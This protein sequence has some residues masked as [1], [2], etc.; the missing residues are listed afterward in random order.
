MTKYNP[1]TSNEV[2]DMSQGKTTQ[3]LKTGNMHV[4]K[5]QSGKHYRI[6]KNEDGKEILLDDVIAKKKGEDLELVYA[7]GTVVTIE[8]FYIECADGSCSVTLPTDDGMGYEMTGE[9]A[10]VSDADVV[11][12]HGDRET[13]AD[14]TQNMNDDY[15]INYSL[16]ENQPMEGEDVAGAGAE[17]DDQMGALGIGAIALGGLAI[18]SGGGD[19]DS[20]PVVDPTPDGNDPD[21]NNPD[22]NNPE[23]QTSLDSVMISDDDIVNKED[24]LSEVEFSG[25]ASNADGET[26]SLVIGDQ[27]VADATVTDGTFSGTVDLSDL[28]DGNYG[29]GAVLGEDAEVGVITKDTDSPEIKSFTVAG[30]N[31]LN[32]EELAADAVAFSGTATGLEGETVTVTL[33]EGEE[34]V[35]VDAVVGEDGTFA[36]EIAITPELRE[37]LQNGEDIPVKYSAEDAAD[38]PTEETDPVMVSADTLAPSVDEAAFTIAG[39]NVV[40]AE[41]LESGA[42]PFSGMT[43]DLEPGQVVSVTLGEG[44]DAVTAEAVV[45]EDGSFSGE[46]PINDAIRELLE[47]GEEV[48]VSYSTEDKAGNPV[49]GTLPVTISADLVAPVVE[50]ITFAEGGVNAENQ[51]AVPLTVKTDSVG[52]MLTLTVTVSNGEYSGSKSVQFESGEDPTQFNLDISGLGDGENLVLTAVVTDAAGNQSEASVVTFDKDTEAPEFKHDV[53][54]EPVQVL[55]T[56]DDAIIYDA[57]AT[58]NDGAV[59][60]GVTY[61]IIGGD[62]EGVFSID[63]QT[64][65]VSFADGAPDVD[66][67]EQFDITIQAT[68]STGNATNHAATIKLKDDPREITLGE[69]DGVKLNLVDPITVNGK[70]YYYLDVSGDGV[71]GAGDAVTHNLL[72]DLLN[73]GIDTHGTLP[74]IG[75]DNS[76]SIEIDGYKLTLPTTYELKKLYKALDGDAPEDWANGD[77]WS[78]DKSLFGMRP[79]YHAT[80]DL[81]DWDVQSKNDGSQNFVVFEVT[82]KPAPEFEV[83][84]NLFDKVQDLPLIGDLP[85]MGLI[86]KSFEMTDSFIDSTI[87]I[88]DKV[89]PEF[90]TDPINSISPIEI[91]PGKHEEAIDIDV[92]GDIGGT[93]SVDIDVSS[94]DEGNDHQASGLLSSFSHAVSN[95]WDAVPLVGDLPLP[96]E[97]LVDGAAHTIDNLVGGLLGKGVSVDVD[98]DGPIGVLPIFDGP[99]P[100]HEASGLLS[101]IVHAADDVWD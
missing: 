12:T 21:G 50:E 29:Y 80:V 92:S 72:D 100:D 49:S 60:E 48:P 94:T 88:T 63:E 77:Y 28:A 31:V 36:G 74:L 66:G 58:D 45:A 82:D 85:G 69:H 25:T 83:F 35:S 15:G 99:N 89:T 22:G 52:E 95:T 84:S 37:K 93:L 34:A 4:I 47:S 40:N 57:N 18:M 76:R 13:L 43:S 81:E 27:V 70:T 17:E 16:D 6:A 97:K 1:A 23:A 8:D 61:A 19:S 73:G 30:D 14:M 65:E 91:F 87:K 5:A 75:T 51:N 54:E 59:D 20:A 71:G 53:D 2:S 3:M 10:P 56:A 9:N 62:E 78:A 39:D 46:A 68:D 90:I 7:D 41:E 11:Y 96:G 67:I 44:E 79:A 33:G 26:V 101:G 24:D 42:V 86:D 98:V 64:G 38:N 55:D 32:S